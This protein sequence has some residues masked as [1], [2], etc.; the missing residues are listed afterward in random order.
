M[1]YLYIVGNGSKHND[2]ELRYSL[3]SVAK[4]GNADKVVI[5]G[6]K[7]SFVTGV[8][9]FPFKETDISYVNVW[10][11]LMYAIRHIGEREIVVMNDDFF[12]LESYKP[13]V[14][15]DGYLFEK[16]LSVKINNA[17]HKALTHTICSLN[18]CKLGMVNYENHTP[19]PIKSVDLYGVLQTFNAHAPMCWR[20]LYGNLYCQ[21]AQELKGLKLTKETINKA[22]SL[23]EGRPH[24]SI[25]DEFLANLGANLFFEGLYPNKSKYEV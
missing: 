10:D 22:V 12:L 25:G 5:V 13:V 19:L 8:E 9:H 24:F 3:R 4:Y 11:K 7:P 21:E 17:Y 16:H 1:T 18:T 23:I 15:S 14:Y 6:H 20:S 2:M